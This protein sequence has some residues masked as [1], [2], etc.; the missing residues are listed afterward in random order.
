MSAERHNPIERELRFSAEDVALFAAASGDRNALHTDAEFAAATAF[1]A[2]IVHG[3][4][5]ATAMLGA[6]PQEALARLRSLQIS[7][8]GPVL[9]GTSATLSAAPRRGEPGT[10]EVKLVARGRTV[11]RVSASARVEQSL[12]RASFADRVGPLRSMRV[13]P[14]EMGAGEPRAGHTLHGR[15]Q[16]A[17]GLD[18][19]AQ[20]FGAAALH[21]HLLEGLAWASYVVGMELPGA[22]SLLAALML[23][24]GEQTATRGDGPTL[25]E[26]ALVVSDHDERTGQLTI[27]GALA[28][29]RTG[30]RTF[31]RIRCFALQRPAAP[32]PDALGLDRPAEHDRGVVVVAGG[33]RGFGAS[34]SL[35]LLGHGYEVHVAYAHSRGRAE[36]LQRLAGPYS[37]RLHL[38]RVDVRDCEAVRSLARVAAPPGRRLAGL[39]LN[40]AAPPLSMSLSAQS[41]TQLTD[42]VRVSLQLVAVPLGSLLPSIDERAGWLLFCS[43][44][45]LA[46]PPRDWPHYVSAK[47]AVEGLAS[48]VAATRPHLRTAVI[49]APKMHTDMTATP[50]G[51]IG[52]A[53]ADAIAGWTAELLAGGTLE[54]GLNTLE[55]EPNALHTVGEVTP[56]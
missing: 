14:A 54:P 12:A 20:R 51:R 29:R 28:T 24:V 13:T 34:L 50:S 40:A 10:W 43:S 48:W 2:P 19:I 30:G 1:G 33:S 6:L 23:E 37:S 3:A 8:S 31:A 46:A 9:V 26:H 49:R 36:E 38:S 39:V 5:I 42:Y 41:A 45:A 35:A 11:A 27:D 44:A 21:P 52:A 53:S 25:D 16:S 7:F 56:V 4:L 18:E 32:Q 47:A 22:H 15:Y 17:P 55:P